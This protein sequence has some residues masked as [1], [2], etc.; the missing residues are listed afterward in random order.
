MSETQ[1]E[2][3]ALVAAAET[4]LPEAPE[5]P[6]ARL[7]RKVAHERFARARSMLL[8]LVEAYRLAGL[9]GTDYAADRGNGAK[10]DR[11]ADVRDRVAYL[12]R[13]PEEHL[14]AKRARLEEFLWAAHETNYADFWKTV[15]VPEVEPEIGENGKPTGEMVETGEIITHQTI[16]MFSEL[17]PDQQRMIESLK[18]TEKGRPILSVYSKMQANIELRKLLGIGGVERDPMDGEFSRLSDAELLAE[19]NRQAQELGIDIDVTYR[20]HGTA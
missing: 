20:M 1:A 11:R 6:G 3:A 14:K 8:P 19:L 4:P 18:Y 15:D 16:R 12:T 17:G 5:T 13:Q 2:P 9:G 7:L 10:L